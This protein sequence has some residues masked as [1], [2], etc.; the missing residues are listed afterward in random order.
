M[1]CYTIMIIEI[2][3]HETIAEFFRR[4]GVVPAADCGGHAGCGKCRVELLSGIWKSCGRIVEAPAAAIPC[5]TRLERGPGMVRLPDQEIRHIQIAGEW[6]HTPPLPVIAEP[7]IAVDAGTTTLAA[8]RIEKGIPVRRAGAFN[9]QCICGDNIITRI[10]RQEKDFPLLR[11]L[12]LDSIASLLEELDF[13]SALRIGFAGNTA[14]NCFLHG[15]RPNSIGIYPFQAPQTF[16]PERTDLWGD[17]PVFTAPSLTGL[18]GGDITGALFESPLEEGEMLLDLGT[19]CEIVFCTDGS[20]YGT[21]AAAGPA[22]EGAG[23]TAGSRAVNGAIDHWYGKKNYSVI[24]GGAASSVCGSA[25]VDLLASARSSGLLTEFGRFTSDASAFELAPG[26]AVSEKDIAEL[27]KAK[28]AVASAVCAVEQY[29]GTKVKKL[30]L[31]G[32]FS[33]GLDIDS[34]KKCGLLP[35]VETKICGNLSLAGAARVALTPEK[36]LQMAA[37]KEKIRELHLNEIPG[38]EELFMRNLRLP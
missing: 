11:R 5:V 17:R 10:A 21:S 18:L 22:F 6:F 14:M 37:V 16:F 29:C 33:Q 24:G 32:G 2:K 31:A 15:I 19:N 8:V 28:A 38:Y 3:T 30:L 23:I 13:Q 1:L 25:L 7:V 34:A 9:G 27:L 26:V 4:K 35:D 36:T 20:L 12:L